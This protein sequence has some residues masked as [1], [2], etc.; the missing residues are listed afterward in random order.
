MEGFREGERP[1]SL[2][3]DINGEDSFGS[4]DQR[5]IDQRMNPLEWGL[6]T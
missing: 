4:S 3:S 6:S 5:E 1:E 2:I